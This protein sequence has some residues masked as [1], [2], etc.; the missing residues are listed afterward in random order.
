MKNGK[1]VTDDE[2]RT[3]IENIFAIGDVIVNAPEL[4]PVAIKEGL[5]LGDRLFGKKTQK[6]DY[7]KVPT[8]V[9]TPLEYSCCGVSEEEALKRHGED[10]IEVFHGAFTPLEWN[11]LEI[12]TETECYTKTVCLLPELKVLGVHY[13]GPNAGEVMQGFAVAMRCNCTMKDI[14]DTVGI[15]PTTA[16]EVVGLSVTKRENPNANKKGC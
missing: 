3:S 16:E 11:W 15:H 14:Q 7:D 5:L 8:T 9:F 10:K 2:Q 4:T 6:M 1:I 13:L 12:P